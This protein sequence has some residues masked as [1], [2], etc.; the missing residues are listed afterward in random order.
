MDFIIKIAIDFV[1]LFSITASYAQEQDTLFDKQSKTFVAIP[2]ISNN[3]VM[4]TGF[5][6]IA[7][8]LYL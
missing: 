1:L 6:A 5:G 8:T 7:M 2:I 3:P 4:K